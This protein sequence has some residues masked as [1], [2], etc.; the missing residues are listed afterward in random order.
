M[1]TRYI[2]YKIT[3]AIAY[4]GVTHFT[5][6]IK[7]ITQY[8]QCVN[9]ATNIKAADYA[10][11][12]HNVRSVINALQSGISIALKTISCSLREDLVSVELNVIF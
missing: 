7:L 4:Y 5:K 9:K 11:G 6:I 2:R 1:Q 10:P 12:L 8:S 3:Y